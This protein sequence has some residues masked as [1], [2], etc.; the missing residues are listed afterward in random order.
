M[1]Y[2]W[3]IFMRIFRNRK[4]PMLVLVMLLGMFVWWI[5]PRLPYPFSNVVFR[6]AVVI[7][8]VAIY[9]FFSR[10]R[11]KKKS[12]SAE[13]LMNAVAAPDES[14]VLKKRFKAA[15]KT[16]KKSEKSGRKGLLELPWYVFIG[17][18]GT[19]KTTLLRN[20]GLNFPLVEEG[21]G[22]SVKGV[23]GTRDC[24]WWFTDEAV[25]LDTAG[26]YTTQD[27]N[28]EVDRAAWASFLDLL[29][30]RRGKRPI[31]G[32]FVAISAD[33]LL[34]ST[35]N[36]LENHAAAV[37]KRILELYSRLKGVFPVYLI[38]TK[39]DL[40]SG[41]AEFFEAL[42]SEERAQVW[43]YTQSIITSDG[44]EANVAANFDREFELLLSRLSTQSLDRLR[45]EP[46]PAR[47]AL[48][49]GFPEQMSRARHLMRSFVTDG[50]AANAYQDTIMLRGLYMTSGTQEGAPIDR[51]MGGI[52]KALNTDGMKTL[53]P[54]LNMRDHAEGRSFFVKDLLQRVAFPEQDILGIGLKTAERRRKVQL[55]LYAAIGLASIVALMGWTLVYSKER[56]Y[57]ASA[58][59]TLEKYQRDVPALPSPDWDFEEQARQVIL[60]LD[61]LA[62]AIDEV[63][64]SDPGSRNL[65]LRGGSAIEDAAH[66][67]YHGQLNRALAPLIET[68]LET[69]LQ[70]RDSLTQR[71]WAFDEFEVNLLPVFVRTYGALEYPRK[72]LKTDTVRNIFAG[73]ILFD[74]EERNPSLKRSL[75]PHVL[76]WVNQERGPASRAVDSNI[77][78]GAKANLI[79]GGDNLGPA[80]AAYSEWVFSQIYGVNNGIGTSPGLVDQIGL[81]ATDALRRRSGRLLNEVIPVIFTRTGFEAFFDGS[82]NE[83]LD[84]MEQDAWI[85][86][87]EDET[88]TP[89]KAAAKAVITQRY[90]ADYIRFWR[91]VLVDV[92]IK[93]SD[94]EDVLRMISKRD[95][96]FK[97][98][99][100]VVASNTAFVSEEEDSKK[101]LLGGFQFGSRS[102]S[103][104]AALT[105]EQQV[106]VAF[107]SISELVGKAGQ[108][109]RIDEV[110]ESI[111]IL[112]DEILALEAGDT[113]VADTTNAK[114]ILESTARDLE[115]TST[116]LDQVFR[117]ILGTANQGRSEGNVSR[118]AVKYAQEILPQCRRLVGGRYPFST[119]RRNVVGRRDLANVFGPEGVLTQFIDNDL[120]A[121]IDR[122]RGGWTWR[123]GAIPENTD[124]SVLR[125]FERAYKVRQVFFGAGDAKFEYDLTPLSLA[126]GADRSVFEIA[127]LNSDYYGQEAQTERGINWPSGDVK[128]T[129]STESG[130]SFTK[131]YV[132]DWGLFMLLDQSNQQ[133]LNGGT[134]TIMTIREQAV[135]ASYR[136]DTDSVDNPLTTYRSWKNF[137]CPSRLW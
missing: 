13:D 66:D 40:V 96:P 25:L 83:I 137:R 100:R 106:T 64:A 123:P 115:Q 130:V 63:E 4:A 111:G 1:I 16:L 103:R 73:T 59:A 48:I 37:R 2:A 94:R 91:N 89:Q 136:I 38:V 7:V 10:L 118:L 86:G 42:T 12:N 3:Q 120:D 53:Q 36:E 65:G 117:D 41:F 98:Y 92:S 28:E 131:E 34:A 11:K 114:R 125:Q 95:S 109:E 27:S 45:D 24:D 84:T 99:L 43:G 129:I 22:A 119:S 54:Q 23:G 93:R 62:A 17:P 72:R 107:Q 88:A 19:G 71:I 122:S 77:L 110:L 127:G 60:R 102:G 128:V 6:G 97:E 33:I 49:L 21:G 47:R 44:E 78:E 20:A 46:N 35:Q 51:L 56:N 101:G 104:D 14:E 58:E 30:G 26:R 112:A 5:G 108:S 39:V 80:R 85:Y 61:T 124:T 50:F 81:G 134:S 113:Q 74:L 9:A 121:L 135:S 57:V 105:P 15:M 68:S 70:R 76:A 55:G 8:V 32:I 132:G 29:R 82:L 133:V 67:A 79:L 18:P 69:R 116:G 75:E 126:G 90:V 87:D 31:N 52:A